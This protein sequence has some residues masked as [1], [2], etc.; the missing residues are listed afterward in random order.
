MTVGDLLRLSV[1]HW[2]V[3]LV[4]IACTGVGFLWA[5][6]QSVAVNGSTSV[7][8]LAP[9]ATD[10]NVLA[11]TSAALI[12]TTGVVAGQVNGP[13]DQ[14]QT[15]SD[16]TLSSMG[17]RAGWSVRQPNTGGQWVTHYSDPVLEVRSTGRTLAEAQ[18][19]METAL[20]KVD[21]ALASLQDSTHAPADA[22]IHVLRSPVGP[23]YT[24]QAGS[25]TRTM[26]AVVLLG[27]FVWAAALIV[28]DRV[29]PE[30]RAA[31]RHERPVA[32]EPL[33]DIH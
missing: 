21:A 20:D 11:G 23:V 2:L 26:G 33:V 18:A 27:I 1:R 12:A 31:R 22:R 30:R 17:V 24:V 9:D 25:R 28:A 4:V 16:V 32:L 13:V 7:V 10:G 3:S 5:M 8:F 15:V 14:P 29:R 19:Q 6:K